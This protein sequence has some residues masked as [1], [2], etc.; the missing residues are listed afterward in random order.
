MNAWRQRILN[1][2][3][4]VSLAIKPSQIEDRFTAK[5][6]HLLSDRFRF[7]TEI[8][9]KSIFV[10]RQNWTGTNTGFDLF[11]SV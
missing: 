3:I 7:N 5:T 1:N 10:G 6:E 4:P 11:P 2:G 8:F 9:E